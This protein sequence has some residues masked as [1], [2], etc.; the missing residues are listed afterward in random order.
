ML[1]GENMEEAQNTRDDGVRVT[2]VMLYLKDCVLELSVTEAIKEVGKHQQ[3]L[4][5]ILQRQRGKEWL[6]WEGRVGVGTQW[7]GSH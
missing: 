3:S 6:Q 7:G 1:C 5:C 4:L 2:W